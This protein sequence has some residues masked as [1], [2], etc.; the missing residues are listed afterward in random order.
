ML[1]AGIR[2]EEVVGGAAVVA[3]VATTGI[4]DS[5]REYPQKH[6]RLSLT[7]GAKALSAES[8]ESRRPRFSEWLGF[9]VGSF[10]HWV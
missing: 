7:T 8:I 5:N 10:E 6:P 2:V 3:V 4:S 9:F 1:R